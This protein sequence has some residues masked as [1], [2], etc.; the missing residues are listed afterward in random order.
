MYD[1]QNLLLKKVV[2]KKKKKNNDVPLG[3]SL[4]FI[5]YMSLITLTLF[6]HLCAEAS[7]C[8]ADT[9]GF[10]S[11]PATPAGSTRTLPCHNTTITISRMCS[12]SGLWET[13]DFTLCAILISI[14]TVSFSVGFIIDFQCDVP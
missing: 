2:R 7:G 11:W 5:S 10:L 14:N 9:T 6:T 12:P 13:V 3:T 4:S 8:K 1:G